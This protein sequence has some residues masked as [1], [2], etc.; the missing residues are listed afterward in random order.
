[1]Q[2]DWGVTLAPIVQHFGR[3]TDVWA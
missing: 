1:M 2:T 3:A